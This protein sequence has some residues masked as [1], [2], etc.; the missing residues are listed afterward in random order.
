[1]SNYETASGYSPYN[2]MYKAISIPPKQISMVTLL[3]P[4]D[5][6]IHHAHPNVKLNRHKIALSR[7]P[8]IY[9]LESIDNPNA[10]IP[11]ALINLSNPI[12]VKPSSILGGI[13][14]MEA[15]DYQHRPLIAIPYYCWANR[16]PSSMQI[17]ISHQ[18]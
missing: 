8:L 11:N 10:K 7:G 2:S 14:I 9:C 17:W 13:W 3:F 18:D 12:T 5:V 4:M 16:E 1:L 6:R 15:Q